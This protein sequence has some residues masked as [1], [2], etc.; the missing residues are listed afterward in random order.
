M[1]GAPT[2]LGKLNYSSGYCLNWPVSQCLLYL[3]F[4]NDMQSIL[5]HCEK[6]YFEKKI[7]FLRNKIQKLTPPMHK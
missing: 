4:K 2:K 3:Y 5:C 1:Q 7:V 6:D